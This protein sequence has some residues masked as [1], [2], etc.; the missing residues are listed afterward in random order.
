MQNP[1]FPDNS[2]G[3][4]EKQ[5]FVN[6]GFKG[7]TTFKMT[8]RHY[9]TAN[10]AY[11]TRAPY[12][13]D[14]YISSRVRDHVIEGL[15]SET[16][17]TA[18][19][20]YFIRSPRIKS[21]I[22][23]FYTDFLDQTW[24]RSFYHEEFRTFVNYI[25]TGVDTR[26][27]GIEFGT[28]I[29]LSSTLSAYLVAGTGDYFYNSRPVVTIARDNDFEVISDQRTVYLKNYK[30]GGMT[31]SAASAG[32][33]YDNPNFWFVGINGNVFANGYMDINPDR[34]TAEAVQHLVVTDPQWDQLLKQEKLDPGFTLDLFAGKSWRIRNDYF[35]NINLSISN[36]LDA[37]DLNIGGFEQ[38]R[39]DPHQPD[40]FESKYFYL[41]GRT[42]FLNL[43]FRF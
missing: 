2:Y 30:V 11:M 16:I 7:G 18:D 38:L 32:L 27:L 12:F 29:V 33:R 4:S 35:L 15:R 40:R 14:A 43:A 31:H 13:R 6:F 25:M 21:R 23:L 36:L 42:Y 24:S 10:A 3:A 5:Q 37:K 22:T 8:G 19:V 28:D 1:R 20:S 39:Y 9:F 34:R 41:Y 26:H 17:R